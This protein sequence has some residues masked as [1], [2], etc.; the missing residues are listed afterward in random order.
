MRG[1]REREREK[2]RERERERERQLKKE[3]L[4]KLSINGLANVCIL[5]ERFELI[6]YEL[7][8]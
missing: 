4:G 8:E 7:Y 2:E 6:F 3:I 5:F 1:E